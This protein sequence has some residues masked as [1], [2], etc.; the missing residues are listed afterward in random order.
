MSGEVP[1]GWYPDPVDTGV[2]RYWDGEQWV[3][4]AVPAGQ[5][6]P[7]T[8]PPADPDPVP[9]PAGAGAASPEAPGR[10]DARAGSRGE[11]PATP[12]APL[13]P[14]GARFMARFVDMVAVIGLNVVVNGWFVYQWWREMGPIYG[15]IFAG[16]TTD[17][18]ERSELSLNLEYAIVFIGLGL[19]FAY[20]VPAMAST[21][22]TYGKRLFEIRVTGH[23][24]QPP[25]WLA[26]LRRWMFMSL[27]NLVAPCLVPLQLVDSLWCTW[28]RPLQQCLH[29]KWARTV[30][31][32]AGPAPADTA[33]GAHGTTTRP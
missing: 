2:Q 22:Q 16:Q 10:R 12:P 6:P 15:R 19:W 5:A 14:L 3:G 11:P 31:V 30:V 28:D 29:D 26:A 4:G 25:G 13:A 18:P 32:Q 8:P 33:P 20:E 23:G 21:G 24:G 9:V 17:L 1:P 7:Q 27:P